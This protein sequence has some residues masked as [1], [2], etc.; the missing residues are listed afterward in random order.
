MRIG[1]IGAGVVGVTAALAL[2]RRGHE[3]TVLDREGVAAGASRGNAGA[4]AFADIIPLA[5]PGI[6]RRAGCSI[7]TG[8]CRSRLPMRCASR[9]G[10]WRSGRRACPAATAPPCPR[11]P[12]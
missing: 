3:V 4:F 12:R 7:R 9:P 10:C 6:I 8:R 1:V 5:T 2:V 11:K